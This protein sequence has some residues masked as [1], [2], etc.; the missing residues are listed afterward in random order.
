MA[1]NLGFEELK[2]AVKAGTIDTVLVAGGKFSED[3]P[4]QKALREYQGLRIH[5]PSNSAL[6]PDPAHLAWHRRKK[7][8]G[9]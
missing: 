7:Y 5:L 2:A 8:Q 4:D 6:W 1:G 3:S 9:T